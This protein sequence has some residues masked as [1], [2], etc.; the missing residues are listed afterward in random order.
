MP[1]LQQLMKSPQKE[2]MLIMKKD[3]LWDS[4][5]SYIEHQANQ[6]KLW[7]SKARALL[8][9]HLLCIVGPPAGIVGKS[10]LKKYC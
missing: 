5:R 2:V 9:D 10:L 8:V 1:I 7:R 4:A 3:H 6:T